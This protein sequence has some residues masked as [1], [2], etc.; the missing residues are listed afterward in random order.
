VQRDGGIFPLRKWQR[1]PLIGCA[2]HFVDFVKHFFK[3]TSPDRLSLPKGEGR[4]RVDPVDFR[5]LSKPLTS[6]LSPCPRG[7]A[8]RTRASCT[9]IV[10]Y[11]ERDYPRLI[12]SENERFTRSNISRASSCV[13]RKVSLIRR[14]TPLKGPRSSSAS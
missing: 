12:K 4:V 2:I 8:A 13:R 9:C 6:I 14:F 11:L 7:E 10:R 5:S 3:S 1:S